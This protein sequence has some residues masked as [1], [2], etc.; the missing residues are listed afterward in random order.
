MDP[1]LRKENYSMIQSPMSDAIC[2]SICESGRPSSGHILSI[3]LII[4]ISW[5]GVQVNPV[6]SIICP[7]FLILIWLVP[8]HCEN[9]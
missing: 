7:Y 5:E 4:A 3:Y 2:L 6:G 1:E 9:K 8:M